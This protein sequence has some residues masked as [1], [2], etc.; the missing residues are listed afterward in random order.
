MWIFTQ[1]GFVSV[2]DKQEVPGT[3]VVRA[4]DRRSLEPIAELFE[5]EIVPSPYNDY[6]YR[7]HLTRE[8]LAEWMTLNI[9]T[10]DYDNFKNRVYA[11]RGDDYAHALGEVWGAMYETADEE[12]KELYAEMRSRARR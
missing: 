7:T 9:Q 1:D 10:L 12:S 8:Q 4:R 6:Q 5:T 2:V 11:T 3:L